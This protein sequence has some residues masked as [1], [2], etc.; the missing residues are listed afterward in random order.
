VKWHKLE[1]IAAE[2]QQCQPSVQDADAGDE[3]Q[4]D[5]L[6]SNTSLR[7]RNASCIL[8]AADGSDDVEVEVAMGA[9]GGDSDEEELP[10]LEDVDAS[11]EEDEEDEEGRLERLM[12]KNLV[13]IQLTIVEKFDSL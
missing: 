1:A 7:P 13:S 8:E 12:G 9:W 6:T 2:R 5:S 3:D 10:G 11:D 4:D